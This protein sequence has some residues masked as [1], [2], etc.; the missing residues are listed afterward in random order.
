MALLLP[1]P[2]SMHRDDDAPAAHIRC[3]AMSMGQ[4]R[5]AVP[6]TLALCLAAAARMPGT[7]A[8][9]ALA[10]GPRPAPLGSP[11]TIAHPSGRLDVGIIL[12]GN[13]ET[14][15]S[16]ELLRTARVLMKGHVYY[17]ASS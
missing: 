5:R 2:P 6:L 3:L 4:P 16:A 14:I 10:A 1:P 8:A 11:L 13:A 15:V 17:S 7:L 9:A 12:P